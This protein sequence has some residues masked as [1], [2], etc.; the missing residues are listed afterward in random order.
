MAAVVRG[1]GWGGMVVAGGVAECV[2]DA[3]EA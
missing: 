3:V 1:G 2:G